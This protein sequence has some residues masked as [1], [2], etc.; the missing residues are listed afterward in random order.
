MVQKLTTNQLTVEVGSFSH[1]SK[2]FI[3]FRWLAGFFPSTLSGKTQITSLQIT[4]KNPE[5]ARGETRTGGR[6]RAVILGELGYLGVINISL[7]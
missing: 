7:L 3:L 2:G 6:W 4:Q 5:K 1:Y